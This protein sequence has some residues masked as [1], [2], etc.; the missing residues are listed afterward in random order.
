MIEHNIIPSKNTA[1]IAIKQS[2]D[3]ATFLLAAKIFIKDPNYSASLHRICDFSQADLSHIT[4]HDFMEFVKFAITEIKLAPSTKVALVAPSPDKRGI[5]EQ[6]ANKIDTGIFR[7]F[8]E[9]EDAI[10][11]INQRAFEEDMPGPETTP[12][13]A[14]KQPQSR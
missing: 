12:R 2:P 14:P 3:L 1:Y 13:P 7:I 4:A 11:W 8:N 9:P 5:F 6:F 10:I